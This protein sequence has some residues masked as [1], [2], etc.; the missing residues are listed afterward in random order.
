MLKNVMS[1]L[2]ASLKL[3]L[4]LLTGTEASENCPYVRGPLEYVHCNAT[5]LVNGGVFV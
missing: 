4:G 3:S 5:D 2:S 1:F